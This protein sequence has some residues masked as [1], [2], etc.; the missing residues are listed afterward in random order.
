MPP[1]QVIRL[2][3]RAVKSDQDFVLKDFA[4]EC[5]NG[6]EVFVELLYDKLGQQV[7]AERSG[8]YL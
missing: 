6:L 7:E 4:E 2:I 5:F 1:R 8:A 3:G